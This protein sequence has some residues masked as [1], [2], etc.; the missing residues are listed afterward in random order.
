MRPPGA[1]SDLVSQIE[2]GSQQ[3]N[4]KDDPKK[5]RRRIY[6]VA[7]TEKLNFPHQQKNFYSFV[8]ENKEVMKMLTLL[9]TCT[10]DIKTVSSNFQPRIS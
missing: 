3:R 9:S 10:A 4:K 6:K 1:L 8:I 7:S 2:Q 5:R